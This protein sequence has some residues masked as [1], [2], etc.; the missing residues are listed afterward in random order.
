MKCW[1]VCCLLVLILAPGLV[2]AQTSTPAASRAESQEE[3]GIV[4]V[5][6][7][8]RGDVTTGTSGGRGTPNPVV[9]PEAAG[10][11]LTPISHPF[12]GPGLLEVRTPERLRCE[13][14]GDEN[15]RRRCEANEANKARPDRGGTHE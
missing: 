11:A 9:T 15:A 6:A 13:L 8:T 5:G 3:E 2:L 10:F 14:I 7:G 4:Q 12:R 1:S